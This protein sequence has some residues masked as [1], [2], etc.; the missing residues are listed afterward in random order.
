MIAVTHHWPILNT[1]FP[2]LVK[3][4]PTLLGTQQVIASWMILPMGNFITWICW[5]GVP[6]KS[7]HIHKKEKTVLVGFPIGKSTITLNKARIS[8]PIPS[9]RYQ[10]WSLA[11]PPTT[12]STK[13]SSESARTWQK[14]WGRAQVAWCGP[15]VWLGYVDGLQGGAPV[16]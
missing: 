4:R 5:F 9:P 13:K 6:K 11:I 2:D 3:K 15:W 1:H 7:K 8:W 16:R 14:I 10:Q 12:I